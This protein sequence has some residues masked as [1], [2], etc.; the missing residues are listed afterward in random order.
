MLK[1]KRRLLVGQ[2]LSPSVEDL[3]TCLGFGVWE[4][5]STASSKIGRW[6]EVARTPQHLWLPLPYSDWTYTLFTG[7]SFFCMVFKERDEWVGGVKER[8]CSRPPL[9]FDA[10]QNSWYFL[11]VETKYDCILVHQP[12]LSARV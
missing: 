7:G 9:V 12:R 1:Y 6:V 4:L 2:L 3:H 5:Q 10:A 8:G 11:S